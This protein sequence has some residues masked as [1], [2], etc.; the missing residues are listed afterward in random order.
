M[1]KTLLVC[2]LLALAAP[3]LAESKRLFGVGAHVGYSEASDADGGA[4]IY[5]GDL[6]LRPFSLLGLLLE[7]G[8]R[9]DDFDVD[10]PTG[11]V[12]TAE[13]EQI[14]VLLSAQVFPFA[15]KLGP[16]SPFAIGGAGWY[17]T[18]AEIE[19]RVGEIGGSF[20]D[21]DVSTGWHFGAGSDLNLGDHLTLTGDIRYVFLETDL[22]EVDDVDAD[23]VRMTAGLKF[24]F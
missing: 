12:R 20:V 17:I 15:D 10:D 5:G 6:S 8:Y 4:A 24:F 7:V 16:F 18:R 11:I 21:H 9:K 2:S 13:L 22:E 3:A 14:P 1:K 19:A 23:G